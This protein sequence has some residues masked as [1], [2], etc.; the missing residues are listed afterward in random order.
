MKKEDISLIT[1]RLIFDNV[2]DCNENINFILY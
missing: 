2:Y 1:H